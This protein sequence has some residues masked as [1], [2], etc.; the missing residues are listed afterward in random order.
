M[1]G[2]ILTA[3]RLRE[4][5][6]YDPETGMFVRKVRTAQRHHAGDRADFLIKS[7]NQKGYYRV[8]IDS[9]RFLAH[10]LAW[11]YVHGEWPKQDID[12]RDSDR[13]NN[14]IANL[15]DVSNEVNRQNIRG[16]MS[17]NRCGLL[18]VF[19]HAQTRKWRARIQVKR[20]GIHLG[21]FV[22]P[23]EAHQAYLVA[24]RKYHEGC[25]I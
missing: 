24:K 17:S 9:R 11:L 14:R 6:D 10:R 23:E 21:L 20:R 18:G 3:A 7:G 1:N 15:R 4:L 25:T 19:Y 2:S 5:L 16:P 12:H 22:T 8:S 13:G